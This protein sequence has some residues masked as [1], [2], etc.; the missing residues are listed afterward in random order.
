[1]DIIALFCDID[2]FLFFTNKWIDAQNMGGNSGGWD[3]CVYRAWDRD[4]YFFL[5]LTLIFSIDAYI[6]VPAAPIAQL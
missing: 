6:G 3:L 2:H 1:M 5:L 4:I